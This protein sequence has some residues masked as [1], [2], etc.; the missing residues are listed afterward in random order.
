M[1]TWLMHEQRLAQ[2]QIN[3]WIVQISLLH[4]FCQSRVQLLHNFSCCGNLACCPE[5]NVNNDLFLTG[6]VHHIV[7]VQ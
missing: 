1:P 6:N 5:Q 7:S 2:L 4:G 3:E